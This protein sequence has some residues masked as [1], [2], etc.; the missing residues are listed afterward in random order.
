MNY[1]IALLLKKHYRNFCEEKIKSKPEN[2]ELD[3]FLYDTLEELLDIFRK[4]YHQYDGF[5]VSG[6]IPYQ[7]IRTMGEEGCEAL[8]EV[9]NVDVANT[10]RILI[11]HLVG[12][13]A[14]RLSRI[15]MDFLRFESDLEEVILQDRFAQVV[16]GYEGRWKNFKTIEEIEAEEEAVSAYYRKQCENKEIDLIITYFYSACEQ[17]KE[18][19]IP[20]YY[21]YPGSHAFW[22]S[23]ENLK[24][25]IALRRMEQDKSAVICID[26]EEMREEKKDKF[27]QFEIELLNIVQDFNT[28]HFN[29]MILKDGHHNLELYMDFA[30]MEAITRGFTECPLYKIFVEKIDFSGSVGYGVGD[31]LY[32]ARINAINASR[33]G[34]NGGKNTGGSFFMDEKGNLTVLKNGTA[35]K[36]VKISEEYIRTIANEVRLSAE[37]IVRIIGV[38]HSL[39]TDKITS[40]DLVYGLNISL[41]NAN[42][43]LSNMEKYQYAKVVGYKRIGNKGRPVRV[44]QLKLKYDF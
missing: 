33:Y 21:V 36:T 14:V 24:N 37:T 30:E 17:V 18:F 13:N 10:Y 6:L 34:R 29:Q 41:R 40:H 44:Y 8:I 23:M 11:Q 35:E 19:K 5:Y 28:R 2:M 38:M 32:H 12:K 25:N 43:F 26:K 39:N 22:Q 16:H 9:A 27:S 15:G 31:N 42:K 3:Y 1:K 20:C 4:I 7:A